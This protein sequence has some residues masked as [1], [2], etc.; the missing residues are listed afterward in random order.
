MITADLSEGESLSFWPQL[1]TTPGLS[2]HSSSMECFRF[3]E[4][5]LDTCASE[6]QECNPG[7]PV[8]FPRR[9]LD[10]GLAGDDPIKLCESRSFASEDRY[11][12]LSHCWGGFD[13]LKTTSANLSEMMEKI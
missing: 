2:T 5:R 8:L 4:D 7:L 9:L 10:I 12:A 6:H 1:R 13:I 11:I 3:L